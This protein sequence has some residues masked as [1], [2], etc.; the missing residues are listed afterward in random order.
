M[1]IQGSFHRRLALF[2]LVHWLHSL[3]TPLLPVRRLGEGGTAEKEEQS[4]GS[5]LRLSAR[6]GGLQHACRDRGRWA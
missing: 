5:L 2:G 1:V 3:G 4:E 6:A